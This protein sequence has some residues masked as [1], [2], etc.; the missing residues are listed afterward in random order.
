MA[1]TAD[2]TDNLSLFDELEVQQAGNAQKLDVLK[3]TY[4][5]AETATWKELFSGFDHLYAITYSS[6]IGFMYQLL[7]MFDRAQIIFGCENV[8]SYTLQE[9]MAFQNKVID[10]MREKSSSQR[11]RLISRLEDQSVHFYVARTQLSHEKIYLLSSRDGRRR[12]IMGSANM[13]F[14]AFGGKQRENICYLDDGKAFDWYYEHVPMRLQSRL[15]FCL[16]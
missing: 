2:T 11:D 10:R 8:I 6:G 9:I 15:S 12:V 14:N 1:R 7:E 13:S 4:D 16:I 5:H 3:L